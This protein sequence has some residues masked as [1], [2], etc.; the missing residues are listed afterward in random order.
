MILYDFKV[1]DIFKNY[2]DNIETS[3]GISI[4]LHLPKNSG[5]KIIVIKNNNKTIYF[6]D[7]IVYQLAY[8]INN[9]PYQIYGAWNTEDELKK[10]FKNPITV[11][12][13]KIIIDKLTQTEKADKI[14]YGYKEYLNIL[15]VSNFY[16]KN[17]TIYYKST[18]MISSISPSLENY[19]FSVIRENGHDLYFDDGILYT[20]KIVDE[21]E[22]SFHFGKWNTLEDVILWESSSDD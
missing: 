16:L 15:N 11:D 3:N 7:G 13:C 8:M 9:E 4:F 6:D 1:P 2:E 12:F 14:K 20:I 21:L 18:P 10:W 22:D 5:G 17:N 19:S